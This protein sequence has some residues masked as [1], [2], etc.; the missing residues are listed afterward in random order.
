MPSVKGLATIFDK[1]LLIYCISQPMARKNRG[2]AISPTV[3]LRAYDL[4]VWTNRETSGDGYR[5]L[6]EAFE[7]LGGTRISTN[8]KAN[9]EEIAEGFGLIE[10]YRVVRTTATGL[11]TNRRPTQ[12]SNTQ[13][14]LCI[15]SQ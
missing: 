1:D 7:R 8:I 10:S 2:E 14:I 11:F 12:T 15:V 9:G 13:S 6:L 3:Q 5:R 4:L